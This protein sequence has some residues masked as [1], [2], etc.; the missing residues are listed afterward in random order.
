MAP[1]LPRAQPAG[2]LLLPG[3]SSSCG[4]RAKLRIDGVRKSQEI[5][6]K[7]KGCVHL[8]TCSLTRMTPG[9]GHQG[10]PVQ[11]QC[12]CAGIS[13]AFPCSR[14]A[15]GSPP[16]LLPCPTGCCLC[17]CAFQPGLSSPWERGGSC[18]CT[19]QC[20]SA[21]RGCT[22]QL[23]LWKSGLA[24]ALLPVKEAGLPQ[25]PGQKLPLKSWSQG[26]GRGCPPAMP[27]WRLTP[28]N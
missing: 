17:P 13:N 19:Q 9:P 2:M 28:Q 27:R 5:P 12:S 14:A 24:P 21:P 11:L 6:Q 10:A 25:N 15:H 7:P 22:H 8:R 3:P 23:L 20:C 18:Y 1:G 26:M 4:S 16:S